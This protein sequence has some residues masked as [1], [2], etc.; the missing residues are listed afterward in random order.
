LAN[1]PLFIHGDGE[2][3]RDFVYV[4]DVVKANLLAVTADLSQLNCPPIFNVGNGKQTS[5]NQIVKMLGQISEQ[6]INKSYGFARVGD[7]KHS[8]GDIK[9]AQQHLNFQPEKT[10]FDGLKATFK[11]FHDNES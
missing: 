9:L 6:P 2:Q 10:V 8:I 4:A 3:T 11:W 5:L 1:K 7:I